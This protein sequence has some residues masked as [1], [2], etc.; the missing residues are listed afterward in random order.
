MQV[1]SQQRRDRREAEGEAGNHREH[2][3]V[4][5]DPSID[6]DARDRRD[7][8]HRLRRQKR[9]QTAYAG[10]RKEDAVR[11][12]A[13]GQQHTLG[14]QL[15][16]DAPAS[17]AE[18]DAHGDLALAISGANEQEGRHVHARHDEHDDHGAIEQKEN[19]FH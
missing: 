4:Q 17:G 13:D 14:E 8:A 12:A 6:A 16:N 10:D 7:A 2:E 18:C 15:T 5:R 3:R 1:R 19:R 11:A 9:E